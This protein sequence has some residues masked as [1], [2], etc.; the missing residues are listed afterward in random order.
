MAEGAT[1]GS[2]NPA[3]AIARE[4][5]ATGAVLRAAAVH[6]VALLEDADLKLWLLKL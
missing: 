6:R 1:E 3:P 4:A 2:D 5:R